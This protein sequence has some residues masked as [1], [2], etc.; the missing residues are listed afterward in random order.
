MYQLTFLL[1]GLLVLVSV[2][3]SQLGPPPLHH[4]PEEKGQASGGCCIFLFLIK[5]IE[6]KGL[7]SN[8]G[9][10]DER[11]LKTKA[12]IKAVH[13]LWDGPQ[14]V[15]LTCLCSQ[16]QFPLLFHSILPFWMQEAEGGKGA[17]ADMPL[18][19]ETTFQAQR[20]LGPSLPGLLLLKSGWGANC[21]HSCTK[22][23][24]S[25]VTHAR[26]SC[27]ELFHWLI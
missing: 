17:E 7:G 1:S 18:G 3:G 8:N 22:Q 11:A 13:L 10:E 14:W 9:E 25:N 24:W 20:G 2:F 4:Y 19:I 5:L 26:I 23:M 27:N 15:G 12:P 21:T 16:C 6:D